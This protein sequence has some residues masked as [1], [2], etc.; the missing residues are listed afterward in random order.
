MLAQ[1]KKQHHVMM[2]GLVQTVHG[3][4]TGF[5]YHTEALSGPPKEID[6]TWWMK[7]E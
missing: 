6:K 7:T 3:H 1:F 2:I 5:D 4:M